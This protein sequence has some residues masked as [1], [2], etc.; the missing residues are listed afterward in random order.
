MT[1]YGAKLLNAES[2]SES[3]K[4]QTESF[5]AKLKPKSQLLEIFFKNCLKFLC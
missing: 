4:H 5:Y 1:Y 3:V 2:F